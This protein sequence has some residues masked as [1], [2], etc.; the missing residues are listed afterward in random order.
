MKEFACIPLLAQTAQPVLT[1]G[2]ETLTL[3]RMGGELLRGLEVLNG[4]GGMSEVTM[5]GTERTACWCEGQ[6]AYLV[7]WIVLVQEVAT[8]VSMHLYRV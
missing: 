1:Y 8:R 7:V 2:R 3:T 4:R 6:T 5:Q